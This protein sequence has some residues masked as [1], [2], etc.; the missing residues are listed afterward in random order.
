MIISASN[1]GKRFNYNW[2]FRN[3]S[4]TFSSGH[5]Y[6][7]RGANG[8]GKTTL[9][10][11]ISGYSSP[12]EGTI[13]F[14]Q[15]STIAPEDVFKYITFC[16]P[17]T[18]LV[19][20][21]TVA[22]MIAFQGKMKPYLNNLNVEQILNKLQL[23]SRGQDYI[24]NLSTGL[25]QRIKVGLAVLADSAIVL[26]DEPTSNLDTSGIAWYRGLLEEFLGEN[27]I[28]IIASNKEEDFLSGGI[29]LVMQPDFL[30]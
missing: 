26:L 6:S 15:D 22:E 21:F 19:E 20:E 7:L 8:S 25:K 29:T 1:L 4:F 10:S 5:S 16:S 2:I 27:R 14:S 23:Q 24:H 3:F 30:K 9:L 28:L 13:Q 11:I 18:E 17:A 12:S